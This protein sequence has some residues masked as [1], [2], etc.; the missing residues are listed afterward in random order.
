L[1]LL[2]LSPALIDKFDTIK[3]FPLFMGE[4]YSLA[5]IRKS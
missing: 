3:V 2:S 4:L 5:F 1:L